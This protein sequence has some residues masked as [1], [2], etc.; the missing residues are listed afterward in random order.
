MTSLRQFMTEDHRRCDDFLAEAEQAVGKKNLAAAQAA[1]EHFRAATLA[2]FSGEEKTLFTAFEERTGIRMG[3]TQVMRQ[4]HAQM[5]VLLDDALAMLVAGDVDSYLGHAETLIIMMQQHNMKEE[6]V[7]YP[8][9]DQHLAGEAAA[10]I[11]Q[12]ESELTEA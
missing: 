6:N 12:L 8:M 3:P 1:F 9:C 7:L 5:R 4:E 10:L 2:H 11:E